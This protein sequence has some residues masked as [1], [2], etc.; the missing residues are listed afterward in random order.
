MMKKLHKL[1]KVGNLMIARRSLLM[2]RRQQLR[3]LRSVMILMLKN[4]SNQNF[5]NGL[6]RTAGGQLEIE[7]KRVGGNLDN[8]G[9]AVVSVVDG[10]APT[11]TFDTFAIRPSGAN[12]TAGTFDTKVFRVDYLPYIPEPTSLTLLGI[13]GIAMAMLR[14][15]SR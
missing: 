12:T 14:R 9:T 1:L 4:M 15:R 7:S 3:E 10:A 6:K 13:G 8:D 2:M 5:V 11:F